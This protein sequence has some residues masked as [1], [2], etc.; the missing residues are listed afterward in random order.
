MKKVSRRDC[1]GVA[2]HQSRPPAGHFY[3]NDAMSNV[4][5]RGRGR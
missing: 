4:N 1:S 3:S 2:H 5:K